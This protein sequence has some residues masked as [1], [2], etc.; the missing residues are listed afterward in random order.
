MMRAIRPLGSGAAG[1]G[2]GAGAGSAAAIG[3]GCDGAM[4]L[5]AASGRVGRSLVLEGRRA[6]SSTGFCTI[7]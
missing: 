6:S 7:W 4:P 5:T 2:A 3:A 1:V